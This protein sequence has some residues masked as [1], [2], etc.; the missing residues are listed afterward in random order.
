MP[1]D[2]V[3]FYLYYV[4]LTGGFNFRCSEPLYKFLIRGDHFALSAKFCLVNEVDEG[5]EEEEEMKESRTI[6]VVE[7]YSSL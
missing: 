1:T 5:S 6:V 2:I 4:V 7:L 3:F